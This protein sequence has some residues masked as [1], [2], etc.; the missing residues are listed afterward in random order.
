MNGE[1]LIA[2]IVTWNNAS[3]IEACIKSLLGQTQKPDAVH[4]YDNA[5]SDNTLAIVERFGEQIEIVRNTKNRGFCVGHNSI[6]QST[7]SDFVLLVNPDIVIRPDYLERALEIM[8]RDSRLGALCGLLLQADA[9]SDNG[10]IDGTGLLLCRSRRFILRN[11]GQPQAVATTAG[12]VFGCDGALP[13]FRRTMIEDISINGSFFDPAFFAHKE[14]QDV[15]WRSRLFGWKTVFEPSCVALHPRVF[16]PGDLGLRRR[17]N[18][19]M[20][21]HTVK[22]DLLMLLKNEQLVG[23]WLD[24]FHIV[25]RRLA[26]M[27]YALIVEPRSFSAFW[28]VLRNIRSILAQRK[29][30]QRRRRASA[31]EIRRWIT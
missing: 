14:D 18:A 5:S 4:V 7:R 11:H 10:I 3:S 23:F 19:K 30:I 8:R 24:F 15:A 29:E 6:I 16:R 20:K 21:Y 26:I 25:P 9:Q 13:L 12:E 17:L 27:F 22:N 28:Y 2:S 31:R 1:T